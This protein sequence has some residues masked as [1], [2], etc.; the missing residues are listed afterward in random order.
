MSKT[1]LIVEDDAVF[2]QSILLPL[3]A[4]QGHAVLEAGKAR[5]AEALLDANPVD[6]LIVD[7]LLPD[8]TGMDFIASLRERGVQI[9]IIFLSA[10][11]K[12][13]KTYRRLTELGVAHVL[14]KPI[15]G[16]ILCRK[17]AQ[18]LG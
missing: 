9:P 13:M 17:V 8:R 11:F 15:D 2:R 5:E 1:I 3:L 16:E 14:H 7:G 12:D 18:L 6:L 4:E 10:F